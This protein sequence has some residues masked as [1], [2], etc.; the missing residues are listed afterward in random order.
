ME[1]ETWHHVIKDKYLPYTSVTTWLRS[2]L[3]NQPL[4]SQFWKRLMKSLPLITHCLRW[5]PGGG[6][7]ILIG[8]DKIPGIGTNS[9]LS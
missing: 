6:D 2:A 9:F 3:V 4:A 8:L 1:D 7:A 5:N